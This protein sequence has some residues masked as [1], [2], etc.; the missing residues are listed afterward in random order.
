MMKTKPGMFSIP[1]RDLD[2]A[3]AWYADVL[4]IAFE[5]KFDCGDG[6]WMAEHHFAEAPVPRPFLALIQ[7][8]GI[9]PA[10]TT[11]PVAGF[12]VDGMEALR[13]ALAR[14]DGWVGEIDA[15]G[16]A[17]WLRFH[18]GDGNLLEANWWEWD[19]L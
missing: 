15:G 11:V 12:N 18:D 16:G 2:A 19:H 3:I 13:E 7:G 8:P 1:T 5:A 4:G 14:R 9:A 17:K 10:D 6:I